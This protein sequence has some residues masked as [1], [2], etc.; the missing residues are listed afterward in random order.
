M[1]FSVLDTPNFNK[2]FIFYVG[3]ACML[4]KVL[5]FFYMLFCEVFAFSTD[6]R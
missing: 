3:A 4:K 1:A 5:R 2:S 6:W